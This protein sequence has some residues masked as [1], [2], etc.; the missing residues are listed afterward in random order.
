MEEN[1]NILSNKL[2]EYDILYKK[3]CRKID[4]IIKSIYVKL[5]NQDIII[6]DQQNKIN[7]L[8]EELINKINRLELKLHKSN[9]L[10]IF[11]VN[12]IKRPNET[13]NIYWFLSLQFILFF[14]IIYYI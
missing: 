10:I 4:L 8:E 14:I 12:K 2:T 3:W 1:I 6:S 7:S 9:K 13:K 5:T 11:L